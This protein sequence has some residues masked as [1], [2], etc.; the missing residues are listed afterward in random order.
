MGL[1][2]LFLFNAT[3]NLKK[4]KE[5]YKVFQL[6]KQE[7]KSKRINNFV[8]GINYTGAEVP[9]KY[10]ISK[11][12]ITHQETIDSISNKN[13]R[14]RVVEIEFQHSDQKDL[15]LKEFTNKTYEDGVKYMAFAMEKD[16]TVITS[17]NDTIKC[18]GVLFERHF[19]V[20]PFKRAML[21]FK[22][23][24]PNDTF[25]LVYQDHLF[26]N[27]IIKFNFNESPLIL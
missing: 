23:V 3:S 24:D 12:G 13:K 21:Y 6:P 5:N 26:G 22:G 27:G 1:V 2:S 17:S 18:A 25:Q 19:N 9:L 20:V 16:F 10:Y 15:L 7:W 4:E 11:N 14:E 8:N